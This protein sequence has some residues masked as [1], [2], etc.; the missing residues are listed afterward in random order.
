MANTAVHQEQQEERTETLT[1]ELSN[2]SFVLDGIK[3]A[4]AVHHAAADLQKLGATLGN[5]QL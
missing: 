1:K 4:S 2:N 5:G 3:R